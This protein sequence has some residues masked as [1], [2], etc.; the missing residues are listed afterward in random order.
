MPSVLTSF[1]IIALAAFNSAV[2]D[3]VVLAMENFA[4]F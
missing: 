2:F 3:C 1:V 4:S